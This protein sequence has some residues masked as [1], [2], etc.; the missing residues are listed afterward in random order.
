MADTADFLFELGTEELPPKAL[1]RL[2]D[3]LREEFEAG[4]DKANLAHGAVKGYA[5]PRR[6]ALW[7]RDLAL[8]QP[9]RDAERRGPAVKAAFD[10]DGNP[11]KAA[12]GF[13]QSCGTTVDRLG[14]M[15]T[16][17]GEWLVFRSH[18]KGESAAQLLPG[19]AEQALQRLPIP[20]R[21]RWGSS[22]A[23]FVRPVHWLIM[24]H[25][26]EVVPCRLLDADAGRDTRGHRFHHPQPLTVARADD[27][28]RLLAAEGYVHADFDARRE[29]IRE[30]VEH[31]AAD[32]G[33]TAMID[34]DLL[35]EVTALVEW[36]API[37]G[38]FEERFL[39]VPQ[40]ALIATMQSNQKYFPVVDGDGRLMPHFITI[41]NVAT[42]HP[43][44]VQAGNERVIRPRFADAMFFWE[45]DGKQR[46]EDRVESLKSVVFQNKL[47]TLHDKSERVAALAQAIAGNIG[48]DPSLARR[49]GMLSRCD[50]QTAMV[51]EFPEMQGI[52][53]R[54]QAR[55]DGEP[56]ELAE[57]MDEFYMPRFSGDD[58]PQTRT[59]IAISLAEKLDTLVGIFGIG[60]KPTGDKD[61]FA[62]R[63]AALGALRIMVEHQ[64]P[65][66][67]KELLD[68]ATGN[69]GDRLSNGA[70]AEEVLAFM[71]ERLKGYYHENGHGADLFEAVAAL[72][73]SSPADFDR[74]LLAVAAFRQLPEAESLAAANKR[75]RNILRKAEVEI[76]RNI[77]TFY[78]E[79][80]AE[81]GLY[82]RVVE[83]EQMV[84]PLV[85]KGDYTG[86]LEALAGLRES[87]DSFFDDVMV[88]AEDANLRN[89]RLA[90]LNRLH[91]LFLQVADIG[92]LQS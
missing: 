4:L 78:L 89:N 21:M 66:D 75:I 81:E 48:A 40:E 73:P 33:G 83:M 9:D 22:D 20:K 84:A 25:G 34:E 12:Q 39:K 69:L 3:A 82:R 92:Q 8:T 88:M 65:L 1:K 43:E 52:M 86:I 14:R 37:H 63:R 77:D 7:I 60:Q 70:A 10:A 16:D 30:M 76:G 42:A 62:L 5:A 44:I 35:D 13:A 51:F 31:S 50:L 61:P 64:L 28:E 6:L 56:E 32:A 91:G 15:K 11:T 26:D 24:L 54:Y 80:S 85:D 58:L 47:G 46:L 27:Y 17:K 90:L 36:P 23:E 49:A 19:I 57:A 55:R 67:L 18:E 87:V 79:H 68:T 71:L 38:G 53:G 74:R 2:R 72:Q 41:A 45:Q 59:G 29:L